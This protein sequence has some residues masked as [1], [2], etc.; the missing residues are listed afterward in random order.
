M[1]VLRGQFHFAYFVG[2]MYVVCKGKRGHGLLCVDYQG[3]N[4]CKEYDGRHPIHPA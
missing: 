4:V 3:A 2:G 1:S